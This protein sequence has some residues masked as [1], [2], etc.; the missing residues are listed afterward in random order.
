LNFEKLKEPHLDHYWQVQL[1]LHFFNIEKGILLYVNKDTQEIKEFIFDY[2]EKVARECLD[3]F[4]KLKTKIEANI[5]PDRLSDYPKNWQC[6]KEG[7]ISC[8][9]F[10]ICQIAGKGE[11][12]W[13]D[14]KSKLQKIS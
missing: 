11:V 13:E 14:F 1:Y 3:Q 7:K 4:E 8:P 2:E 10:E 9:Y 5:I 12:N 6:Q